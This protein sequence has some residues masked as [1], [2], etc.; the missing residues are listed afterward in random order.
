MVSES[1]RHGKKNHPISIEPEKTYPVY[2]TVRFEVSY[3]LQCDS[4][5]K[6]HIEMAMRKL[7]SA[8]KMKLNYGDAQI[9]FLSVITWREKNEK[10]K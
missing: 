1:W 2:K 3:S 9:K 4:G 10:K 5:N 6:K 7:K 8:F